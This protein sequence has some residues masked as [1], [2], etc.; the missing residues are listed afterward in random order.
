MNI[1]AQTNFDKMNNTKKDWFCYQCSLQFD[2]KHI[3]SLHIR[4]LHKP[5]IETKSIKNEL[6]SNEPL[7]CVKKL[8][9]GNQ[10]ISDQDRKKKI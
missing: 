10:I 6:T 5:I 1:Q 9:L 8:D 3:Y 4:L 2:S 7:A